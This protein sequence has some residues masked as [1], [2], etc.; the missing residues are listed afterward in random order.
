MHKNYYDHDES[1]LDYKRH[2]SNI[3]YRFGFNVIYNDDE[4]LK[5]E[6]GKIT[7]IVNT[8]ET[9][10]NTLCWKAW[11]KLSEEYGYSGIW[12]DK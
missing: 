6:N 3:S 8:D 11:L 2:I 1:E 5:E 4:V 9:P 12:K 10:R 7:L